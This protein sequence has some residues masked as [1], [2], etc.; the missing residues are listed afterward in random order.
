MK[1]E[2]K[3][4]KNEEININKWA[5]FLNSNQ[6]SSPFQSHAFYTFFNSVEPNSA[7]AIAIED[8]TQNIHAL[9]VV[10]LQ[11]EKGI[12]GYFSR[13]AIIYGGPLL[14]ISDSSSTVLNLILI[15]IKKETS[16]SSIYSEIRNLNDYSNFTNIYES[17]NW[18]YQK[19]LNYILNCE[20]KEVAWG[21]FN[22]NRVRQIKKALK[23]GVEIAEAK[24]KQ[25]IKEFYII[26]SNLYQTKIKKP[27]FSEHFFMKLHEDNFAKFLLVKFEEKIIGGIVCPILS[28]KNIYELYICGLDQEYKEQSPSVMAT[29]AAIEYGYNNGL[30]NFDFMGAGK[31]HEDYGVRDFKSKF[32][33]ELVEHGR[34]LLI[35]KPFL[36][37]IGKLGLKIIK[38]IKS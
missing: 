24:D 38:K 17:N 7:K 34:F 5:D 37:E 8:E 29:Y 22:N 16:I 18:Q 6:Y 33:G 3:V 11:K 28:S 26:L 4:V 13:R 23:L 30:Q 19:H 1:Q 2:F 32:G 35:N 25:E 20:S 15:A 12:K 27:L 14:C 36:F 9:C 31:P 10:I 21:N